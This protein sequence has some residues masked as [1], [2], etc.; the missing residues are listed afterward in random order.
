MNNNANSLRNTS[1]QFT[2][3]QTGW[4]NLSR[5]NMTAQPEQSAETEPTIDKARLRANL[6]NTIL[7]Q[8]D[9]NDSNVVVPRN[10]V[11]DPN[12][13]TS[14]MVAEAFNAISDFDYHKDQENRRN[15]IGSMAP[16]PAREDPIDTFNS[17]TENRHYS[18]IFSMTLGEQPNDTNAMIKFLQAYPT[19]VEFEAASN[20]FMNN[21]I[22]AGNSQNKI[23]EYARDMSDFKHTVYGE[24]QDYFEALEDLTKE[25]YTY[26]QA[27]ATAETMADRARQATEQAAYTRANADAINAM[28]QANAVNNPYAAP[29]TSSQIVPPEPKKPSIFGK[30]FGHKK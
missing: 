7:Q 14:E 28:Y 27:K 8:A 6:V 13:I 24:Q 19:P 21:I 17:I 9:A 1:E 11:E 18:R 22:L 29:E 16:A 26:A 20:S 30:L 4:D 2:Q 10:I 5:Q 12:A 23:N 25:Y 15:L 3:A